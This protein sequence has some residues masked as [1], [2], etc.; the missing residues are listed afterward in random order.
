MSIAIVTFECAT[1]HTN[2]TVLLGLP[3]GPRLSN[4]QHYR[5]LCKSIT[6]RDKIQHS[7]CKEDGLCIT[8]DVETTHMPIRGE[9]RIKVLDRRIDA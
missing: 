3:L 2:A 4:F 5:G 1:T 7:G 8:A 9:N 6:S